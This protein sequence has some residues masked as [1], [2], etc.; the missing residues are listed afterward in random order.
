MARQQV[1]P[2][3]PPLLWS[4]MDDAFSKINANFTELYATVG[5]GSVVD[6]S[7]L[8]TDVTPNDDDTYVLG[9]ETKRWKE[10][11]IAGYED[12]P[13]SE[14][15]GVWIDEAHVK[16]IG[17][18][19]DLP[20]NST[21]AGELIIDP[22]KTF[23]KSV[24][25]DDGNRV[26]AD[27]FIDTLNLNSGT[28]MQ[29]V[30]DS[31]AESVT[32]NNTGVTSLAGSTGISVSSATGNITLTNTGVRSVSNTSTLPAGRSVGAGIATDVGTGAIT[33]TNTGILDVQGGFGIT[34]S[35]D[36]ATGIANVVNTSPAQVAFRT[37]IVDGQTSIIA[38]STADEL[39][40]EE[41][42]GVILT[43][44]ATTDT[45][46]IAVDNRLDITGSV[47]ADGSTQLIDGVEGIIFA[48][49][50]QGTA[51]I[52]VVGNVTGNTTGYHTGDVKGTVFGDDST[53]IVD[54]VENQV[55]A[56]G[57]FF[58]NVTGNLTGNTVGLHTGNVVGDVTGNT[59]GFHTGDIK[60]SVVADDSTPLIDGVDGVIYA[61]YLQGTAT[62]DIKGSVFGDDSAVI[63]D[64]ATGTVTGKI[65][66]NAETPASEFAEGESGEIRV[67]DTYIWV[68]TPTTGAW[69]KVALTSFGA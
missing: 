53:K 38:D 44:D 22:N 43:T 52:D 34:V 11:R 13:G 18:T 1:S 47:Y 55:F 23:F 54:A 63:I 5:G 58:G 33:L 48:Q 25:V 39:T 17:T 26:E 14:F 29:L 66:P 36:P 60:G 37:I 61:Q 3:Y 15:N 59:T 30:V 50:L 4:N 69:K 56:T 41:G 12:V 20:S 35:V 32:I 2:G 16:G 45:L 21:V 42:Y 51:T 27:E 7:Q 65:A 28:A 67:D 64:G 62:I 46:T 31:A 6:F 40:I 9:T 8:E 68:K 10:V 19:V 49:Y 57:G 24:Q